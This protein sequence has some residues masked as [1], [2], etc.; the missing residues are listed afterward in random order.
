MR[1][2][3]LGEDLNAVLR[4]LGACRGG[5]INKLINKSVPFFN[6]PLFSFFEAELN[7]SR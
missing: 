1:R 2:R 3:G 6:R 4:G 7:K 5:L